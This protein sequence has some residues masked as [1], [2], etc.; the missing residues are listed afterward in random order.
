MMRRALLVTSWVVLVSYLG[1]A[2]GGA[3]GAGSERLWTV[4][5]AESIDTIRGMPVR[6][7]ECRGLG[8]AEGEMPRY[9]RFE[10]VAGARAASDRFEFET[11]GVLYVLHPL[12]KYDGPR[13]KHRLTQVR[14]VGGP[15][16]P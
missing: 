11:L 9:R 12:G 15:G 10:C 2:C 4:R 6:V 5:Q 1:A 8:G 14:F 13:S 16:I 3:G 7:R